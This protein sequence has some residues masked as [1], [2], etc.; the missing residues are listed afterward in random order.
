MVLPICGLSIFALLTYQSF[1]FNRH[2]PRGRYFWWSW[3][4]LDSDPLGK[5]P[6]LQVSEPCFNEE[7]DCSPKQ[8][9]Y[10]DIDPGWLVKG[11]TLV[12]LPAFLIGIV[13]VRGMARLGVSEVVSFM[14]S[15]PLLIIAWFCFVG[16][17]VDRWRAKR[18]G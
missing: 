3:E 8:T 4:R 11:L 6:Q 13:I 15:M 1:E 17:L 16:W 14:F 12:A 18:M 7:T 5:H 2:I 10:I 9:I